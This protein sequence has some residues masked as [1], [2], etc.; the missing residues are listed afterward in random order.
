[1]LSGAELVLIH[2]SLFLLGRV[3]GGAAEA[4]T[5]WEVVHLFSCM[6]APVQPWGLPESSAVM[7][8]LVSFPSL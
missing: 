8:L 7:P 2:I 5:L 3:A 4:R 1:M 6:S